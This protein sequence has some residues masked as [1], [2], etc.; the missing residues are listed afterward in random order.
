MMPEEQR[1]G[2]RERDP[3]VVGQLSDKRRR[4]GSTHWETWEFC[5]NIEPITKAEFDEACRTWEEE[6]P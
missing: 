1:R 6:Y 3:A 2:I 4:Q 5:N